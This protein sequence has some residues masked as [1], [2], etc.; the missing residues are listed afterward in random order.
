MDVPL[1]PED[2][3]AV[4]QR[5]ADAEQQR[6]RLEALG[7]DAELRGAEE[8][9][10]APAA[11]PDARA[12][13]SRRLAEGLVPGCDVCERRASTGD[14][15]PYVIESLVEQ[16]AVWRCS[17]CGT[18][19]EEMP[20]EVHALTPDEAE[21]LWGDRLRGRRVAIGAAGAPTGVSGGM[22][23]RP[24]AELVAQLHALRDEGARRGL[25]Y[26]MDFAIA[27][28]AV[29]MSSELVVLDL[30]EDA[31]VYFYRDMGRST[32]IG[33]GATLDEVAEPFLTE[34]A[35]LAAGR[36]R[37]PLVGVP[38]PREQRT[39]QQAFEDAQARGLFPGM[40]WPGDDPSPLEVLR[41]H[42]LALKAEAEAL[43]YDY[44]QD[45]IVEGVP[46]HNAGDT[47]V[48]GAD[49]S[50]FVVEYDERGRRRLL[51]RTRSFDEARAF[52]LRRMYRNAGPLPGQR[53]VGPYDGMTPEQVH[54]ELSNLG[55][56]D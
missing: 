55:F 10:T 23:S 48:L 50:D 8:V 43:G 40:T 19:W 17:A 30:V 42:G 44:G 41:A 28:V 4:R 38:D 49:G 56:F 37:G 1:S 54:E 32:E 25:N 6:R 35:R 13:V 52:F 53:Q 7:A 31:F 5:L 20:H 15:E 45:F 39:P 16:A 51:L 22:A 29:A 24:S 9:R 27:H 11:P 14:P 12:D 21:R 34:V 3:E 47:L 36:G 33:R 18:W 26:G 46:G 2:R